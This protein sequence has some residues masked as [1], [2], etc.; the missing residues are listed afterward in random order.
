MGVRE[1]AASVL[2]VLAFLGAAPIADA[3]TQHAKACDADDPL[4]VA[5]SPGSGPVGT[6]L[7][8]TGCTG[9]GPVVGVYLRD[10]VSGARVDLGLADAHGFAWSLQ[11]TIPQGAPSGTDTLIAKTV[12]DRARTW[13]VVTSAQD[14]SRRLR[15]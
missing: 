11:A 13:F 15:S 6:P 4:S 12:Y 8:M 3:S 5:V 9:N 14:S 7:T 10:P 1:I 2:V